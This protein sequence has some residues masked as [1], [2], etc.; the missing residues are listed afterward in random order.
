MK[1]YNTNEI[2]NITL[3]GNAGCGKTTLAEAMLFEGGIIKRRGEI[4]SKN[5]ISDNFEIEHEFGNS[6]FSSILYTEYNDKKINIIDTPGMDDFK[7]ATIAAMHVTGSA[8]LVINTPNGIEAGTESCAKNT[9]ELGKPL[10][11]LFNHMDSEKANFEQALEETKN[12]LGA[13]ATV[14]QYPVNPGIGFNGIIDVLKMKYYKYPVNGG[15]PE[16]LDIPKE[17]EEKAKKL[18]GQLVEAA[19][20]NDEKLMEL[21]FDKGFL[22]EDEMRQGMREGMS[23]RSFFPIFCT[24]GKQNIGIGRL[25]EFITNITPTPDQAI[26][27]KEINGK[28]VKMEDDAP[29]SLFV[30]KASIEPHVGEVVYFKVM[31]GIVREGQDLIN[32]NNGNKERISQLFVSAGKNRT[33]VTEIHPGDFGATV[34]LKETKINNTLSDKDAEYSFAP[35]IFPKYRHTVAMKAVNQS[36]EEKVS[37]MFQKLRIEDPSYTV[38]YS[39]ELK[40]M[41]VH[42]QGEYHINVL[43]WYYKN[44]FNLDIEFEKPKIPYRETITKISPGEYRHKKQ[45]GGAGQF[46]EVHLVIEPY[47]EGSEPKTMVNIKGKEQ[48]LSVRSTQE[49]PLKWGGKLI[50]HNCIVGGSIDTRFLPAIL[51]GIMEKMEEG[52]LT[53]SYA[54]DI[55]VYVYDGKMHPVDSNE[56][57]FRIAGR[58]AFSQAF[59]E[60][61]PKI[62]EPVYKL[63]VFAPSDKLGDIMSDLQGRRGLILGM[64]SKKGVEKLTAKV[65]LKE[66]FKYTTTLSSITQGRGSFNLTYEGYEKVPQEIQDELLAAYHEKEE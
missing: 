63:E 28:E 15:K 8:V 21:Y 35:I 14:V 17:E 25:M 48:K 58:N 49:Y 20:V 30:F 53:G 65:P 2:R 42:C 57:S 61:G 64:D 51:K 44:I 19:A 46:G 66:M 1:V 62:L 34:K 55:R 24:S 27:L 3:M 26:E 32:T 47:T 36:D 5:T 39:K 45:S 22:S 18:Y 38:E 4:N 6:I 29:T 7:G 11:V 56:I 37:E 9:R 23:N 54:R 59:K 60:A 40:Q 43:K 13:N 52:P 10:I 16:I 50:F 33:K 31:S 12:L 41:L